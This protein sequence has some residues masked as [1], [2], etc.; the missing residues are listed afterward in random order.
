MTFATT[1]LGQNFPRLMLGVVKSAKRQ[2]FGAISYFRLSGSAFCWIIA[3]SV[4]SLNGENSNLMVA[5]DFREK[6]F[7]TENDLPTF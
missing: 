1:P 4:E 3:I 2:W 7:K 5:S 6:A